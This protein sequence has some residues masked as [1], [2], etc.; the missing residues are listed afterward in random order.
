MEAAL[1]PVLAELLVIAG[2]QGIKFYLQQTRKEKNEQNQYA[3][4]MINAECKDF[5][6]DEIHQEEEEKTEERLSGINKF[7]NSLRKS[8]RKSLT[9]ANNFIH[10]NIYNRMPGVSQFVEKVIDE[11]PTIVKTVKETEIIVDD[12]VEFV[13]AEKKKAVKSFLFIKK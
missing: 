1:I 6:F 10:N 8:I 11:I 7:R 13:Q 3:S 9:K 4:Q 2:N 12:I 5:T